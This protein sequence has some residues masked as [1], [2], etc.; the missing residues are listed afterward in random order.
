MILIPQCSQA[1]AS[2]WIA[3]SKESKVPDPRPGTSTVKA[4]S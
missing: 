3:H 1:G 4:A 2:A